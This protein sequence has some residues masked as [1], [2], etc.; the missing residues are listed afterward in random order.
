MSSLA[1]QMLHSDIEVPCPNCEYAIWVRLV[2]VVVQAAVL[3]PACRLRI[4]LHDADGSMHNIP[5][6]IES[7]LERATKGLFK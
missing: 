6:G 2:E 7:A 1:T 4:W 5:G 3:C